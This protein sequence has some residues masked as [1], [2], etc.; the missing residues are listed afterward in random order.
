MDVY[1]LQIDEVSKTCPRLLFY[2]FVYER[3][4]YGEKKNLFLGPVTARFNRI[5]YCRVI[6]A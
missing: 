6:V 4:Y 1:S 2:E 5:R 3:V